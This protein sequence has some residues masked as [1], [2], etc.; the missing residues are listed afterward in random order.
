VAECEIS[1]ADVQGGSFV[2]ETGSDELV[3][4]SIFHIEY[5]IF[6]IQ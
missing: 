3:S 2:A 1:W 5:S 4:H 6:N